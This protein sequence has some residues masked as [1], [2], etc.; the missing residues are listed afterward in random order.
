MSSVFVGIIVVA[1]LGNEAERSTAVLAAMKNRMDLSLDMPIGSSTQIA[2]FVASL[3]VFPSSFIGPQPMELVFTR[4]EI[5]W[6]FSPCQTS[7]RAS[8]P[9]AKPMHSGP[10]VPCWP[11][12]STSWR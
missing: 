9:P 4:G 8:M 6:V 1:I 10:S 2:P 11:R 7:T 5:L 3:L 12:P